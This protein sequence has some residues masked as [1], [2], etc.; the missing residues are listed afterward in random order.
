MHTTSQTVALMEKDPAVKSI[1]YDCLQTPLATYPSP[2]PLPPPLPPPPLPPSPAPSPPPPPSMPSPPTPPPS[3]PSAPL[4]PLSP[5]MQVFDFDNGIKASP[6][7]STGG[8]DPMTYAFTKNEGSTTST[9]TGPSAGVGGSGPYVYAETSSPRAPGDLFT[10]TYDGSAC[11][12]TG[13]GVSTVTFYY[14][15]YGATMG[16]LRV[17]N[18]AGEVAWSLSGDQGDSWN[19]TTVDIY[20]PSFAFEYTRGSSWRGDAAV[21]LVAVSCGAG[22]PSP[23]PLPPSPPAVPGKAGTC[24]DAQDFTSSDS[25]ISWCPLPRDALPTVRA[26]LT[27]S[28]EWMDQGWGGQKGRLALFADGARVYTTPTRAPHTL[29]LFESGA[30]ELAAGVNN[31][32]FKYVVGGGG[33]HSITITN[34]A[35]SWSP[36]MPTLLPPPSPS[37]L[38]PSSPPSPPPSPMPLPSPLPPPSPKP[39]SPKSPPAAPPSPLACADKP[40]EK[41][42]KN[43]CGQSQKEENCKKTCGLCDSPPPPPPPPDDKCAGKAD[44]KTGRK[45][46]KINKNKC[47]KSARSMKQCKKQCKNDKK[48]KKK[49]KLCQKTCCDLGFAV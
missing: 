23:P 9:G 38:Q 8:G 3:P 43:K 16:E 20:S 44:I 14:H 40:K 13:L 36:L 45:K 5:P 34:F 11:S 10:L 46:C 22:P 4:P 27:F 12:D 33:G 31:L 7:W 18:A 28:M 1:E 25:W 47:N 41:C 2:P 48:K 32:E 21:A 15:M 6:G 17:T 37:L 26:S 29:T 24:R 19:A 42:K 35:W 39:P 49:K 30:I